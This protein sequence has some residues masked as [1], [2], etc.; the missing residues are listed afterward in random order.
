MG[1]CNFH[2]NKHL[3]LVSRDGEW[4]EGGEFPLSLV[5][6]ATIPKAKR[7]GTLDTTKYC[8]LDAIHMDI[9]FGGSNMSLS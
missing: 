3:L 1:C 5:S 4:V 7:G 9:A 8:Y 2:N 6:Y